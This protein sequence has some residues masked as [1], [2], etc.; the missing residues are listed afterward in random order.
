MVD[1]TF[2]SLV[3]S[4]AP[5]DFASDAADGVVTIVPPGKERSTGTTAAQMNLT[6]LSD[7]KD[8]LTIPVLRDALAA[9]QSVKRR[10]RKR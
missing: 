2:A 5:T 6:L 7:P 9:M 4:P 1:N 10:T 8:K 3:L